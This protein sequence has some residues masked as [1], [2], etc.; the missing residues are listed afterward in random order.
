MYS[1]LVTKR[2]LHGWLTIAIFFGLFS[3]VDYIPSP[4]AESCAES[5]VVVVILKISG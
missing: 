3:N 4:V 1:K 2:K 5:S